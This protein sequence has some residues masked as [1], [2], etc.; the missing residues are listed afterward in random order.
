MIDPET[1]FFDAR[2]DEL[3]PFCSV[4]NLR[5]FVC[6]L[7]KILPIYTNLN[8]IRLFRPSHFPLLVSL[9]DRTIDTDPMDSKAN[10]SNSEKLTGKEKN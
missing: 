2:L 5:L 3:R 6:I 9:P 1:T 4:L 8:P 7:W 10:E